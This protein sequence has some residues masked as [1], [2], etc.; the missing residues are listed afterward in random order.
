M[1]I[2]PDS[3][4][5][6][7]CDHCLVIPEH[8]FF[9]LFFLSSFSSCIVYSGENF[10]YPCLLCMLSTF[11][12][13]IFSLKWFPQ[14]ANQYE[15]K[16][17]LFL[18]P[19]NFF[20]TKFKFFLPLELGKYFLPEYDGEPGVCLYTNSRCIHICT[21]QILPVYSPE[22]FREVSRNQNTFFRLLFPSV[23][24]HIPLL[25]PQYGSARSM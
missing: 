5:F 20:A 15:V 12:I 25:Q 4:V 21:R 7:I 3:L 24:F 8:L 16:S 17:T 22:G 10:H 9:S 23:I 14:I 2:I 18:S 1:E 6:N 11:I 13:Y 19:G